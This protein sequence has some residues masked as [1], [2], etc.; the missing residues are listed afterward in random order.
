MSLKAF[1]RLRKSISFRMAAWYSALFVA[2]CV[3]FFFVGSFLLS[4]SL[5]D[6][7]HELIQS[8]LNEYGTQYQKAGVEGLKANTA[9]EAGKFLVRLSDL[10]RN[11][12]FLTLPTNFFE[13]DG[14]HGPKFDLKRLEQQ[15]AVVSWTD[16]NSFDGDDTLE[17]AAVRLPDGNALQ[18]GK[19]TEEREDVIERF[20]NVFLIVLAAL[21]IIGIAAGTFLA[22]R[23]L[24]PVRQ[25]TKLTQTIIDTGRIDAR[26]PIGRRQDELQELVLL[27]NQMLERIETLIKGMKDSLDNVAHDLRTPVTRL[28]AVAE[29]ALNSNDDIEAYKEA[30]SDCLEESDRVMTMLNTLMDI[31][32]AETGVMKLH[33]ETLDISSLVEDIVDL[34]RYVADEKEISI[35]VVLK[36][37]IYLNIDRNRMQQVIANL[38][39]N[40]LKYTPPG[41]HI[42]VE[43]HTQESELLLRIRDDG[44]GIYAEELSRVWERLYRG[45]RSRSQRGL[46]LGLSFVKA[47]V[48]AHLGS[49]EVVSE[50]GK[51]STFTLHL[52]LA[53]DV[54]PAASPAF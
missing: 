9:K 48:N 45:D 35:S 26:V 2:S 43:A 29:T 15:S 33:L 42:S 17:I 28:R 41:G 31:S 53:A 18:I 34:Y 14:D 44:I 46:G 13:D 8:K 5:R 30:L 36:N 11:T 6:K 32:E 47:I 38:L 39:D 51:G 10:K 37:S 24:E 50:P 52:P 12:R 4:S 16:F 22:Y 20:Q 3:V 27:S 40:A 25:I 19:S 21:A 54:T 23:A 1:S 7:D 49:I